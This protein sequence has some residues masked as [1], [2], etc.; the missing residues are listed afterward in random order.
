[1]NLEKANLKIMVVNNLGADI[2]DRVEGEMKAAH[3]L[4][5]ASQALRQA[6]IKIPR[7]LAAKV[8]ASLKEGEIPENL[9][10]MAAAGLV[11]KYLMKAGEFLNHLADVEGQKAITQL[12]RVDGLR[13]AMQLVQKTKDEEVKKVQIFAAA[14]EGTPEGEEPPRTAGSVARKERGSAA[15]RKAQATVEAAGNVD[16]P[17]PPEPQKPEPAPQEEKDHRVAESEA[18]KEHGSVA[19]R[20]AEAKKPQKKTSKKAKPKLRA[21]K[22]AAPE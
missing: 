14:Q 6:A 22:R 17:A 7:D 1:M 20:R 5:G 8:D 4:N 2:E 18:R 13:Q 9:D 16:P 10:A 19:E 21:V 12:G 11:K 3:E 15:D